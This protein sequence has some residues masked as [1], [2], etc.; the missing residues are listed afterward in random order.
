MKHL[1][2][3]VAVFMLVAF[4]TLFSYEQNTNALDGTDFS[5]LRESL[6]AI[7]VPKVED[8]KWLVKQKAEAAEAAA[9]HNMA[10]QAGRIITYDVTTK[11]V[12]TAN[13]SEFKTLANQTLNDGRGWARMGVSFREVSSGGEFT[14]VL[15]QASM[16]PTFSSGC[17]ADWSCNAGRYVVINQDRWLGASSAWNAGGGS[18]RDYRHMVVN[19]ETGHWLGHGHELCG[20]V[21]TPAPVMQQQSISLQGCTFNPWP[22]ASELWIGS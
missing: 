5:T 3:G 4:A 12:I 8:P 21:G 13:F 11:G 6:K 14:L 7:K 10:S 19:H 1:R 17:S 2:V 18:L 20:G 16:L 22:L 15:A 9:A